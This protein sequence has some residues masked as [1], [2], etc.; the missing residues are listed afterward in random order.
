MRR[1]CFRAID[2]I[3]LFSLLGGSMFL[4]VNHS[5]Q[6]APLQ[7]GHRSENPGAFLSWPLNDTNQNNITRLPDTG[8]THNFLGIIDC[9]PYPSLLDA[10]N[11]YDG[12]FYAGNRHLILSGVPDSRVKWMNNGDSGVFNNAFACYDGHEGIDISQSNGTAVL[13]AAD[14]VISTI[15]GSRY[16]V[17][18]D[19]VNGS[20]Q[21]WYTTYVHVTNML[22]PVG[23]GVS[24]G[25]RIASVGS[26]H[27]HFEVLYGGIYSGNARNPYGIDSAP[28]NGC[29]WLDATF[30]PS[31]APTTVPA[32]QNI[33]ANWD[34]GTN[35]LSNWWFWGE[36]DWAFYGNQ[37]LY[38]KRRVG[39]LGGNVGQS[40]SYFAPANAPFEIELQLGNTSNVAKAPGIFLRSGDHWDIACWF[41]I[42]ANSPLKTYIVRGKTRADWHG[43]NIEVWPDPPDGIPDVMMD[44]VSVK[45]KPDLSLSGTE[46]LYPNDA[47]SL[48]TLTS[49]GNG[50]VLNHNAVVLSWTPG[51]D[52]GRPNSTPDYWIQV[53]DNADF[54]SPLYDTGWLY[55]GTSVTFTAS[56]NGTYYW[57]VN[58]GDGDKNSGWTAPF[59]FV[60]NALI[61]DTVK[62]G[63]RVTF[64]TNGSSIETSPVTFTA[65]AWDNVEGS[66]VQAVEFHIYYNNE[67]HFVGGD[68]TAPYSVDWIIPTGL[69][70]Q[71]LVFTIHVIDNAWNEAIDPGGLTYVNYTPV[72]P[73]S[74]CGLADSPWPMNRG[75]PR[76]TGQSV[77]LGP[78]YPELKW[79]YSGSD[80]GTAPVLGPD[81][82][83]YTGMGKTMLALYPNGGIK[84]SYE[85][86]NTFS[87][88]SGAITADGK[89]LIGNS[90]GKLYAFYN[91][92]RV[93]WT[94]STGG[95]ISGSPVVTDDG[96]IYFG[97]SDGRLISLNHDGSF[98]WAFTGGIWIHEPSVGADGTVYFGGTDHSIYAIH[99]NGTLKWKYETQGFVDTAP[100]IGDHGT[101]VAG[102]SDGYLY[103][104]NS[105]NGTLVWKYLTPGRLPYSAA[106]ASD[107]TIYVASEDVDT[108]DGFE[109]A[110]LLALTPDGSLKWQFPFS[111]NAFCAPTIGADGTIYISANNGFLY[112]FRPDGTLKWQIALETY[113]RWLQINP[114][115]GGNNVIYVTSWWPAKI[116]A[117]GNVVVNRPPT[118]NSINP[119]SVLAGSSSFTLTATGE[120]FLPNSVIRWNS[121]DLDTTYINSTHLSAQVPGSLVS[122]AGTAI[123]T[124]FT[125][126]P[127]GGISTGATF[128]ISDESEYGITINN[129]A[130][131]TSRTSVTLTISGRSSAAFMQV[132]NDGGF[133]GAQWEPFTTSKPWMIIEYGGYVISR[134]VYIRFKDVYGNVIPGTY[135]DDI[136]LDINAPIGVVNVI[137]G[138][139]SPGATI[140]LGLSASDEES[141]VESMRFSSQVSFAGASWESFKTTRVWA[142]GSSQTVYVQFQDKA[143]N[144]SQIYTVGAPV[145]KVYLP[146]ITR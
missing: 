83:I 28:Y 137:D 77:L 113:D 87:A 127:G 65:D 25:Q 61:P 12:K 8:W 126:A 129:G 31:S 84:W 114:V 56:S 123:V 82:T 70:A 43:F 97:S 27:L 142:M 1:F 76:K 68:T 50:E 3:F 10:G 48:P 115:I 107:G 64:P 33:V 75:N 100:V 69:I 120:D 85:A 133:G 35:S 26:G 32:N 7:I 144:V 121:T 92:G 79:T 95:W 128:T 101:L 139:P 63:G 40:W 51:Y 118:L 86:P 54:S 18:H 29:L 11:W 146:G 99:P 16:T 66:G 74:N 38:F 78:E 13:A 19:N 9:G 71:Q 15:S 89:I 141:G 96:T 46:C 57:R 73:C 21:T 88:M 132:S 62:P 93:A 42:P 122:S 14:G 58:Q 2:V 20:G 111:N 34:F 112:S 140:T 60:V 94:Y 119:A 110:K 67:W 72:A 22:Y 138:Q 130:I 102:S 124:V 30:C 24:R 52:D 23:T 39:N 59:S 91:D 143:G 81:G 106:L 6:A 17:R 136:I 47:P 55:F 104:I 90:D 41:T 103:A 109:D 145:I 134:M 125:P 98:K 105:S 44:N 135:L 131:Y 108:Q 36:V 117:V 5:V 4:S 45:Y 37:V 116:Y 80:V 49:P 53:D